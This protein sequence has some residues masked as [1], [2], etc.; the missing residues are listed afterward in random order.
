MTETSPIFD[1]KQTLAAKISKTTFEVTVQAAIKIAQGYV[2]FLAVPVVKEVFEFLV[3]KF[4]D[5]LYK[6]AEQEASFLIIDIRVDKQSTEYVT[7]VSNLK[8]AIDAKDETKIKEA[9]DEFK[10]KLRNLIRLSA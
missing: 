10:K 6:A 2:P 4:M 7:A 9:N 3:T 8:T 1:P 5:I